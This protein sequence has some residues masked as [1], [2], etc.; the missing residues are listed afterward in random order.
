MV[1]TRGNLEVALH[2]EEK[3]NEIRWFESKGR[4]P[5][6]EKRMFSGVF[7]VFPDVSG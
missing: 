1:V 2:V 3:E 5:C 7:R 4:T 6:N